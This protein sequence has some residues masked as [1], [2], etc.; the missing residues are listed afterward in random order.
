MGPL[1]IYFPDTA[2]F[3]DRLRAVLLPKNGAF[4]LAGS[5]WETDLDAAEIFWATQ[6]LFEA[7]PSLA[8]LPSRITGSL[9]EMPTEAHR[10]AVTERNASRSER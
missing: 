7:R 10:R 8:E 4:A 1:K 3:L 5:A 2:V 9:A 6:L